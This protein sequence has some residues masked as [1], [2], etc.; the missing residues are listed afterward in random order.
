MKRNF[1]H[2]IALLT[3]ITP[4]QLATSA[5]V[6][7][8]L[9]N[10]HSYVLWQINHL[11]FST[12]AGKWYANGTL[13]I[14]EADHKNDNVNVTINTGDI[15]TGLPELDKHLKGKLFFDVEKFPTSTFVSDKVDV[16]GQDTARVQGK[17][18]VHG[19]TK[20]IAFDVKL[21][22][23]GQNPVNNL[24]GVGFSGKTEVKRSDYGIIAYL[25]GLSDDVKLDLEVEA[26]IKKPA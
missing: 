26:Y 7:Y 4:F 2:L 18:T 5:P 24:T 3:F 15:V 19:V 8:T 9:D 11:G 25:P 14:D 16:T 1:K 20:Q 21:N 10:Q 22:K 6:T 12:Q 17:L 13:V 23:K